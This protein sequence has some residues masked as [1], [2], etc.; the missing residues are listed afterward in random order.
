MAR[1]QKS[2]G[3]SSGHA[4]DVD[5]DARS[6]ATVPAGPRRRLDIDELVHARLETAAARFGLP[7][8]E[9]VRRMIRAAEELGPALSRDNAAV[10]GELAGQVRAV[11]R[12]LNQLVHAIRRGEAKSLDEAEAVI[13]RL[14][15]SYAAI[16]GELTQLTLA[17][18]SRVR[19]IV[20]RREDA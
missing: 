6:V 4:A 15:D 11:G 16:N 8:S 9:V 20:A 3:K 7:K 18:G 12:N 19:D 14:V 17:Y 10:V 2:K 1:S 5:G 13:S